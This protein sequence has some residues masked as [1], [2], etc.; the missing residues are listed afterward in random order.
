M[1][2]KAHALTF[3]WLLP[4][5]VTQ[6]R[7]LSPG[8]SRRDVLN[9]KYKHTNSWLIVPNNSA[10]HYRKATAVALG[11]ISTNSGGIAVSLFLSRRSSR[12]AVLAHV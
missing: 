12:L 5:F 8:V 4:F 7:R 1:N 9:S 11:F 6:L 10:G 3:L 2:A